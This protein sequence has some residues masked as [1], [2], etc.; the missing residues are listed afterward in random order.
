MHQQIEL[1]SVM[2]SVFII[3]SVPTVSIPV[4]IINR[5]SIIIMVMMPICYAYG[6][7]ENIRPAGIR[8]VI[9]NYSGAPGS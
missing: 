5:I 7:K 3:P 9:S 8:I 2:P 4:A 1:V 6:R